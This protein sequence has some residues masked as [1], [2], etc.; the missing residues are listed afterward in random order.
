MPVGA[1]GHLP[2]STLK[3]QVHREE[4]R[5]P[6]VGDEVERNDGVERQ[7]VGDEQQPNVWILVD[8]VVQRRLGN[9]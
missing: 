7:A 3:I 9:Q 4:Q 1:D 6:E 2:M 8:Q 5:L